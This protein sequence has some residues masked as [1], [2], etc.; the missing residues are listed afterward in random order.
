MYDEDD[1]EDDYEED[2]IEGEG[3]ANVGGANGDDFNNEREA[4]NQ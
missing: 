3:G 2:Y 4:V 1:I